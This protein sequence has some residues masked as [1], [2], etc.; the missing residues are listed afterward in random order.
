MDYEV[1][2]DSDNAITES[3]F[4]IRQMKFLLNPSDFLLIAKNYFSLCASMPCD[5][6]SG[7]LSGIASDWVEITIDSISDWESGISIIWDDA[8]YELSWV[9]SIYGDIT[10]MWLVI[11]R[12]EP[13]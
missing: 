3:A 9:E 8:Y 1:Y 4:Q 11:K 12:V 10:R 5:A 7:N 2:A 13:I 6:T